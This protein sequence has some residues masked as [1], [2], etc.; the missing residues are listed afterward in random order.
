MAGT[1]LVDWTSCMSTSDSTKLGALLQKDAATLQ[2]ASESDLGSGGAFREPPTAATDAYF[3]SMSEMQNAIGKH[4]Y[5]TAAVRA[6]EMMAVIPAWIPVGRLRRPPALNTASTTKP[7]CWNI[8]RMCSPGSAQRTPP[9]K[10]RTLK[11]AARCHKPSIS[12]PC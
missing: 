12:V 2:A 8:K 10:H 6:R 11:R 3:G 7:T 1:R 9:E 4:D 5:A